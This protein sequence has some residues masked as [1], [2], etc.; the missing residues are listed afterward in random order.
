MSLK[1]KILAELEKGPRRMKTLKAK[2]GNDKK[3][4]RALAELLK[5]GRVKELDGV[6]L[7]AG[8]KKEK[9]GEE[10]RG[11]LVKLGK[12]FGFVTPEEGEDIFIPGRFLSGAMPGD[13]VLV[14]EFEHPQRAGSRE[15]EITAV[16]KEENRL[17]GTAQKIDGRLYLLPDKCPGCPIQIKKSAD[18]GVRPG[19]KAAA[20]ILERGASHSEHR[21][22][23]TVRFGDAS[24]AK[25]CTKAILYSAGIVKQFPLGC[26]AEAKKLDRF[27]LPQEELAARRDLREKTIFT[28]D[29]ASTKDIDDAVSIER[30]P[31]GYL[32]G[33]H[34]ADVSW[35]VKPDSQL[36]KEAFRRGTSVYYGDN[37]V[38]MLPRQ[39]SNGVCSLNEGEDRLAFSCIMR[40][41]KTG[42]VQDYDFV[43]T[44]I[45]SRLKGVYE[46]INALYEES[47]AENI[48][49]KYVPVEKEL[50]ALRELYG[51]LEARRHA[52]GGMEIES[53]EAKLTLD[54]NGVCVGVEK[55]RRGLS[56]RIIE[57]C[58]L[59]ANGCAAK[60]ARRMGIPFVYRVHEP[61]EADRVENLKKCLSLLGLPCAFDENG[62]TQLE[63]SALLDKTRGTP[64]ERAVHTNIL[65]T[66]SKAKYAPVPKGH[67]GLALEDYAHFTSP[68][69]RYPDLAI[70]R[71]LSDIAAG[72]EKEALSKR[73]LAFAQSASEQSSKQEVTA[74][75]AE[76]ACEDCYKAEYM[77]PRI[78]EH[79]TGVISSVAPHGV[80]V[81][82]DNMVEG[83]IR[84]SD[85][86]EHEL[87]LTE[88]LAV[89][90]ELTGRSWRIG[91][92]IRVELAGVDVAQ[93][94][95]DFVPERGAAQ[96]NGPARDR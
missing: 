96:E 68:I 60:L 87:R 80:Y 95:I 20:E 28:I 46:E 34:I 61:P 7:T 35:F 49:E 24:S 42:K 19:E 84:T 13:A 70:H 72:A 81:A 40:L 77:K 90:D 12:G 9:A 29:S 67:Y 33:V 31:E 51:Q 57:E 15:G 48:K 79:F 55:R 69:R 16:L 92:M 83:L 26:K 54:E 86:S 65:R 50:D 53:D 21:A 36:D 10:C 11:V 59:L 82:L 58:M 88:G 25:Q 3:V 47:A 44:V 78:G 14:K 6:Y 5:E 89:K 74:M 17:V 73:Y 27:S 64:L 43:K 63:L 39:L 71:I 23:V 76:R 56:E 91:D 22:G 62:P 1:K 37:V 4:P 66:L 85:L 38:P 75:Q 30:T 93:G 8:K 41:D 2:L 52:R 32:L 45:R 18:G 94:N